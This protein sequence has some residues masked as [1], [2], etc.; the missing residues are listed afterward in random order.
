MIDVYAFLRGKAEEMDKFFEGKSA[1]IE[2]QTLKEHVDKALNALDEVKDSKIWKYT[3][4]LFESDK[5]SV[6]EHLR[7][8]LA[9]HDIGKI[10]YQANISLD[11]EKGVKYLKFKG[12]E[13][14]STYLADEYFFR[15]EDCGLD[16]L[17]ILSAILYHHHA[18]GLKERG[19]IREL[20]V[21]KTEKE[22]DVMCKIV[23]NILRSHG[24]QVKEFLRYLKS[25]KDKLE[26][27]NNTLV[28]KQK[29]VNDVY[30]EVDEINREIW[31][32]FIR[33]KM[34]RK[35]MLVFTII[36]QICDYKGS[37]GRTKKSPKFY[38]VLREFIELY[39]GVLTLL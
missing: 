18:M 7:M 17:L 9:F 13:Y 39:T 24:L 37:E 10:F 8:I 15:L 5:D 28:L 34:F 36:L 23:G 16:R 6:E 1:D 3:V 4:K 25:L 2:K 29:F 30:R 22:Y 27:K 31:R 21:C 11:K 26:Y 32:L 14:F 35:R 33:S 12:H 20:R 38:S 19:K